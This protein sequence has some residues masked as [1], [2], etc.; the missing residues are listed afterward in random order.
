MRLAMRLGHA[1]VRPELNIRRLFDLIDQILRHG[2]GER[3]A[4]HHDHHALRILR[5]VHRRL[6][7][8][9]CAAHDV[10][11]FALAGQRFRGAAAVVNARALQP[12]DSRSLQP[13]P[14]HARRDHQRVAGDL[15]SVRQF[16][17][18]IRTFDSNADGFLRRQNLHSKALR[19]HHGAPRQIAAA[20]PRGKSEIV[21]DARTHSRLAARRF[22]LDHHG[23]QA[24]GRAIHSSGQARR[25]SADN[26]QIV[27]V[28]LRARAQ[29]QLFC[30]TSAGYASRS[31]VPSGK[32]TTGRL[33][34]FR[35]QSFQKPLGFRIVGGSSTSIH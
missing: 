8:R 27:E 21:F 1:G 17:D 28:R 25:A 3:A 15:V 23:V 24:L 13:P 12:V 16:D 14:L 19:L 4:A 11:D 35:A 29:T 30:A 5:E 9:I 20:E 33:G 22:A 2:A 10:N 31:F 18:A 34:R 26:R 32:S 7:R 6:A